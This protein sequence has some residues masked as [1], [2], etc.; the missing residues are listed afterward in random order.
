MKEF[1]IFGIPIV[2]L[3]IILLTGCGYKE[4]DKILNDDFIIIEKYKDYT[5]NY[6]TYKIYNKETKV[7]Y[8][9][10]NGAYAGGMSPLYNADG[11]LQI[12]EGE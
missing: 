6:C 11:T 1:L 7:I 4:G 12:Y 8:L 3:I 9:F 5:G 2:I 10:I